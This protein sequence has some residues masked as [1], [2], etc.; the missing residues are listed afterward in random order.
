MKRIFTLSVA[1]LLFV[2]STM[3][4][5][6]KKDAKKDKAGKEWKKGGRHGKHGDVPFGK[7]LNLTDAQKQQI[8]SLN[9]EYRSKMKA[10]RSN[11]NATVG[12]VKKQAQAL[13]EEQH[14]RMQNILTAEQKAKMAELK[15]KRKAGGKEKG[16]KHFEQMQKDLNLTADQSAKLKAQNE[17]FKTKAEAIKNNSSLS[18]EQKKEQ[19]K[20]LMEQRKASTKSI[21]TAEQLQKMEAKKKEHKGKDRKDKK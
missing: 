13:R 17:E 3:A 19:F 18:K 8:K 7:E 12:D 16:A 4:Q 21:L 10:L 1:A 5:N 15:D 2:G 11:D 6:V 14:S 20:S 9:E